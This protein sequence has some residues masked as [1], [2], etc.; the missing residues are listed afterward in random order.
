[1]E[2]ERGG[3]AT[4]NGQ[5]C[6]IVGVEGDANVPDEHVALWYGNQNETGTP[7]VWTVPCEYVIPFDKA[8]TYLH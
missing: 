7:Q 3:F 8:P 6:V 5:L 1:M 2:L 4:L